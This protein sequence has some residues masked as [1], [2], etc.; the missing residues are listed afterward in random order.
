MRLFTLVAPLNLSRR[1]RR[2][3]NCNRHQWRPQISGATEGRVCK[4]MRAFTLDHSSTT[5]LVL[6]TK[7]SEKHSEKH[8]GVYE[9]ATNSIPSQYS[10]DRE[11]QNAVNFVQIGALLMKLCQ[12]NAF[13]ELVSKTARG[14]A[15]EI[16]H[17]TSI[18]QSH[19]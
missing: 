18:T 12:M 8:T 9:N 17:L 6:E 7:H 15:F 10:P 2:K 3:Q 14:A 16:F 4:P 19:E 11:D 5:N 13:K 1:L